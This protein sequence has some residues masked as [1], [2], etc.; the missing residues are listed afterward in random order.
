MYKKFKLPLLV[1]DSD[2]T[3][4][5][6]FTQALKL[7]DTKSLIH[8]ESLKNEEL[9]EYFS[10]ISL[11][12]CQKELHLITKDKVY[13]GSEVIDYLIILI[14]GV[15]KISWLVRSNA[16]KSATNLFYKKINSLRLKQK[17]GC[18]TCG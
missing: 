3:L 10:S 12:E 15:E 16:A 6:R 11:N 4:C 5:V 9:Y 17:K 2:C 13:R 7:I 1:F 8:F 14:P 18:K